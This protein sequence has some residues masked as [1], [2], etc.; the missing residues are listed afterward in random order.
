MI[1]EARLVEEGYKHAAGMSLHM[2]SMTTGSE[3][4]TRPSVRPG[5]RAKNGQLLATDSTMTDQS[6]PSI[7]SRDQSTITNQSRQPPNIRRR[8]E[9]EPIEIDTHPSTI[10]SDVTVIQK[11]PSVREKPP[12][13]RQKRDYLPREQV[14]VGEDDYL[15]LGS[16]AED[17]WDDFEEFIDDDTPAPETSIPVPQI[18]WK[19]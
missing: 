10:V 7:P 1:R 5:T 11:P 13:L 4:L 9:A 19:G 2:V 17:H 8:R 12:Q 16:D 6:Y 14:E 15:M 18:K 3:G